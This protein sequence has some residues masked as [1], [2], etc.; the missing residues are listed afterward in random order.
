[1]SALRRIRPARSRSARIYLE[2]NDRHWLAIDLG[3]ISTCLQREH[4][5]ALGEALLATTP[6][7]ALCL[8]QAFAPAFRQEDLLALS[9]ALLA[10][11]EEV[12]F[13][14][15]RGEARL[16]SAAKPVWL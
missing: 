1:M 13:E 7:H 6:A 16:R 11:K 4:A 2:P 14:D 15:G 9:S 8:L 3:I 5:L 12:D 10:F